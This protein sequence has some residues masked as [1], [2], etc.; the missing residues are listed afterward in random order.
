MRRLT[1][2]LLGL[3]LAGAAATLWGCGSSTSPSNSVVYTVPLLAS[4]ETSLSSQAEINATGTAVITIHKDT[5]V[6]D[7]AVSMSNFPAGSSAIAA[8]IHGPNGPAGVATGVFVSAQVSSPVQMPNG[9]GTY[10]VTVSSDANHVSQIVASPSTFYFNV[11]TPLNPG[12][13]IR[14]QLQ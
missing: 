6:I 8:H 12:G 10:N 7:F 14:G 5:N 11:H 9:S 13:A 2:A 3:V 1:I 4:N